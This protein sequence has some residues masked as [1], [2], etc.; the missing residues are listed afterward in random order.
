LV[1]RFEFFIF[2]FTNI[3]KFFEYFEVIDCHLTGFV[4]LSPEFFFFNFF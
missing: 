4:G 1:G 2:G 3:I